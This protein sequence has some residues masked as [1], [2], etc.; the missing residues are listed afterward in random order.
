[1]SERERGGT[2]E[3]IAQTNARISPVT[4]DGRNLI[5]ILRKAKV[6]DDDDNRTDTDAIRIQGQ[7]VE[8]KE[9]GRKDS[10][11]DNGTRDCQE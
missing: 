10:A 9:G 1:M 4:K 5:E 8:G 7:A 2:D 6:T 11:H 3:I